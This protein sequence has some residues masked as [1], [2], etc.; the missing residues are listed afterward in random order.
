MGWTLDKTLLAAAIKRKE[1]LERAT[2]FDGAVPGSRPTPA[3]QEFLDDMGKVPIR[4]GVASNQGGKTATGARECAWVFTETHPSWQ[5]PTEWGSESLLLVIAC[6]TLKQ[7]ED[8]IWRKL[9]MLLDP[10]CYKVRRD[11]AGIESITNVINGNKIIVLS[12]NNGLEAVK[13]LQGFVAHWAWIDEMPTYI[14]VVEEMIRRVASRSGAFIA[15]FTPKV[16]NEQIRKMVDGATLPYAKR[17]KFRMFDN[18]VYASEEKQQEVLAG[19]AGLPRG[20]ISTILEG[21]WTAGEGS[22]Y[23]YD[24]ELM[25]RN[26]NNYTPHWRHV[27]IVDPASSSSTGRTLWAEDPTTGL[28]YVILS[29]YI[30]EHVPERLVKKVETLPH[31]INLVRRGCDPSAAW[32]VAQAS[33]MGYT[34]ISVWNKTQRKDELLKKSQSHLGTKVFISSSATDL[35]DELINYS[36]REDGS[37]KVI[38][39]QKYHL[40]DCFQYGCDLLPPPDANI[41][42]STMPWYAQLRAADI[43]REKS[44]QSARVM[45]GGRLT[46]RRRRA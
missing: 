35:E 40:I 23:R 30:N 27:L 20:M 44:E 38:K 36:W 29:D 13:R 46:P 12:Y 11:S 7:F 4:W 17:Y 8:V 26:P 25:R 3:Q 22:V 31:G 21:E 34:Y 24:A 15:T 18:P 10:A 5:R 43:K 42:L 33:H 1:I 9:Q 32:Y 14:G 28:W 6:Q 37:E 45:H 16:R 2:V 41:S 39:A 19:L